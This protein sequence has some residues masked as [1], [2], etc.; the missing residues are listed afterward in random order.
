M[1]VKDIAP[2]SVTSLSVTWQCRPP[3][4]GVEGVQHG[5]HNFMPL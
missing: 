2:S 5:M 3:A 4:G 1:E